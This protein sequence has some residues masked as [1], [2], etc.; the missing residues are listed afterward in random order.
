MDLLLVALALVPLEWV[1]FPFSIAFTIGHTA[2][3]VIGDGGPFW[4]Y[5]RRHFGRGI[6]DILGVILFST[7]AGILI[8]LAIYGYL[9]GS[10]FCLGVLIG[11]RFGDAWLSHVCMRNTAPGPNPGL[12]TSLLYL[13]EVAVVTLSGVPVSPLGFTIAWGAFAAFWVV[14]FLIRKR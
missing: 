9:C 12:A 10:A 3:E 7:L 4:C 2:E 13:V 8:L 6:D 11:A 1:L 14:S 5:Y